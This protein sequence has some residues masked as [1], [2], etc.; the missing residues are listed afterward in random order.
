MIQAKVDQREIADFRAA[1]LDIP[2]KL[3]RNA[4][5][6]SLAAG[7]KPVQQIARANRRAGRVG[8]QLTIDLSKSYIPGSVER[9]IKI[10]TSRIARRTGDVGVYVNVKPKRPG[11]RDDPADPF[12][13]RWL[14]FGAKRRNIAPRPFLTPAA[15]ALSQS[16]TI[17]ERTLI[18]VIEKLNRNPKDEL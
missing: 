3:R 9:A 11:G 12:Y 1:L 8:K 14:E 7:A 5:R 6:R 4:L 18:P 10:R 13:W 15:S 2:R 16:L 17:F